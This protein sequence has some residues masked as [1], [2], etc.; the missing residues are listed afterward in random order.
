MAGGGFDRWIPARR[1][2]RVFRRHW[3]LSLD[4]LVRADGGHRS[5]KKRNTSRESS[6]DSKEA[7]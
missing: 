5:A 1:L 4:T 7:T 2:R 3:T 6:G